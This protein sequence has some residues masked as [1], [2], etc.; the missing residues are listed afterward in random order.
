[1]IIN[2]HN[3]Y[4]RVYPPHNMAEMLRSIEE[5]KH[6]VVPLIPQ[7]ETV[8]NTVEIESPK[9]LPSGS[10]EEIIVKWSLRSDKPFVHES[11]TL[12]DVAEQTQLSPRLLSEFLNKYYKINFCT[13]INTLRVDEV[14]RLLSEQPKLSLTEISTMVGFSDPTSLSKIFKKISQESPSAYKKRISA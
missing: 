5:R 13:W 11:L 10:I 9:N 4:F 14:K 7:P 12:L 2:L 1:M 8:E 3:I 6:T